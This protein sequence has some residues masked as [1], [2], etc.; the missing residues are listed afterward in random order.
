GRPGYR[1]WGAPPGG[2][3]DR[4]SADLANALV[5]NPPGSAVLEATLVGGAYEPRVPLALA[6]AGAPMAATVRDGRGAEPRLTPPLS[7]PVLAGERLTLGASAWGARTYLAVRGGWQTPVVL[8]SRSSEDHLRAGDV[9]TCLEGRI[10]VRHPDVE[11]PHPHF[12]S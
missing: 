8:D 12:E 4:W 3:F 6:L 2:A 1:A 5:G 7:F 9:V 10:P 11:P